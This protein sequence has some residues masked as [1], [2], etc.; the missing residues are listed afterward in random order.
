[1][2]YKYVEDF[3]RIMRLKNAKYFAYLS[4]NGITSNS[5]NNLGFLDNST[6]D[7]FSQLIS[8]SLLDDTVVVFMSDHGPQAGA[9]SETYFKEVESRLPFMFISLG[10]R[11][12]RQY[13]DIL[14]T[15]ANRLVTPFDIHAT[16]KHI[17]YGNTLIC[18]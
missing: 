9:I 8:N 15:N 12:R 14:D 5:F 11:L 16:L 6:H 1:M 2:Y 10:K 4:L 7:F 17:L 18:L 3:I 13:G